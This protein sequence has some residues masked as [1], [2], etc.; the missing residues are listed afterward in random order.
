M[1][2]SRK[3]IAEIK[4]ITG[5]K[6]LKKLSQEDLQKIFELIGKNKLTEKH[7]EALIKNYPHFIQAEI[8]ALKSIQN[9]AQSAENS[10]KEVLKTMSKSIEGIISILEKLADKSESDTIRMKIAELTV[11][12][13]KINLEFAKISKGIN[14]DNNKFWFKIAS[15]A[16]MIIV[17]AGKIIYDILD[18]SIK[19]E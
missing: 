15:I 7:I 19:K 4:N 10:Q 12:V 5:I 1:D 8:E 2:N 18:R 17:I 13:S 3:I 11:E 6:D 9:I 14:E 16:G